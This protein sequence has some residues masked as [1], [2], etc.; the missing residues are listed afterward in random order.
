M[1]RRLLA[2]ITPLRLAFMLFM[3][4]FFWSCVFPEATIVEDLWRGVLNSLI[5][6]IPTLLILAYS[7]KFNA[8]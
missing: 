6:S 2:V 1:L 8:S 3:N 7:E 4:V 5:I